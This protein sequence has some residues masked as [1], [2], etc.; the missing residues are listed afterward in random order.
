MRL[1][2]FRRTPLRLVLS[3]VGAG[4]AI[5]V[6]AV[7][8][9]PEGR[10]GA[11]PAPAPARALGECAR[12]QAREVGDRCYERAMERLLARD[13]RRG[14]AA[15][16]RHARGDRSFARRCHML[17]HPL[18]RRFVHA[19]E[20]ADVP[21]DGKDC[22]AGF[23]HGALEK[24]LGDSGSLDRQLA[25]A[26]CRYP[27]TP[28]QRADCEHGIGH[29]LMRNMHND[30]PRVL[31]RCI[32][33][34]STRFARHCAGGAFMENRFAADGRDDAA[35]TRFRPDA[36]GMCTHTPHSLLATC[37]GWAVREVPAAARRSHCARL[38]RA[39]ARACLVGAGAVS[40]SGRPCADDQ[41]CWFGR[42]YQAAVAPLDPRVECA[43][44]RTRTARGACAAGV[45]MRRGALSLT[46]T[47][48]DAVLHCA[49]V[50]VAPRMQAACRNGFGRRLDPV[51]FV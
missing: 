17:M 23:V 15:V 30:L 45:G 24:R 19:V 10:L 3:A 1:P 36:D 43:R 42:G 8:A 40:R 26:W 4:A 9:A 49:V 48:G 31:E 34:G 11:S 50:F 2:P 44:A 32:E 28:S 51:D 16:A 46:G 12:E 37:H 13:V 41:H 29:V 14:I 47:S 6:I 22:A 20:I 38:A 33:L 18:G 21:H 7:L 25:R 35:G 39:H 27:R 5:A